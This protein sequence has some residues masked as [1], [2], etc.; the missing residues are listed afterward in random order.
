MYIFSVL[1]CINK[2]SVHNSF[3]LLNCSRTVLCFLK[4]FVKTQEPSLI[5]QWAPSRHLAEVP[6]MKWVFSKYL[7]DYVV[8]RKCLH[9]TFV[10]LLWCCN[11]VIFPY[12]FFFL[13]L[14]WSILAL[15]WCVSFCFITKWISYTY[16]YIPISPPSCISL[17]HSL[18]HPLGGHKAPR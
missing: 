10:G 5:P 11:S 15:Q 13:H 18:S 7:V 17:P 1:L 12:S 8:Y 4:Y 6:C 2:V 3:L 14:Y 16:T 9:C